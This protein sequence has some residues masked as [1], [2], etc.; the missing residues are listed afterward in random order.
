MSLYS[1][2]CSLTLLVFITGCAG[3]KLGPTNGMPA[4]ARSVQVNLFKNDTLEPR[5]IEAVAQALRKRLQQDGTYRLD[6][7]GSGDLVVN[8][9]ITKFEREGISF[10]PNDVITVRDYSLSITAKITVRDRQSGKIVLDRDVTGKTTIRV[11][12]DMAS[13]QR[14]A[15]PMIADDLAGRATSLLVDGAW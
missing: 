12:Q 1:K 10:Q 7:S 14:Q 6:T 3:Y 13:S 5:L 8:G 15:V 11:G 9:V 4:G 2:L